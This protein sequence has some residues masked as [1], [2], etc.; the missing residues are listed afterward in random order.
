[1]ALDKVRILV[2]RL[3][4]LYEKEYYSYE[5]EEKLQDEIATELQNSDKKVVVKCSLEREV[6]IKDLGQETIYNH[7]IPKLCDDGADQEAALAETITEY[8]D[9]FI[10]WRDIEVVIEDKNGKELERFV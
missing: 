2:N 5:E 9:D 1:M 7:I 8:V 10:C 3:N 4:R 6:C